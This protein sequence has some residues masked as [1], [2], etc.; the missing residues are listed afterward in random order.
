MSLSSVLSCGFFE[1]HC[2]LSDV[3][4][5]S[6]VFAQERDRVDAQDL[7][8]KWRHEIDDAIP[9]QTKRCEQNQ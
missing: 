3:G 4:L 5:D 8:C 2:C 9:N 1:S 6:R 7:S